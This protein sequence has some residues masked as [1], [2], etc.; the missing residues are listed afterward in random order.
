LKVQALM[1][2]S[3]TVKRPACGQIYAVP[4]DCA[5]CRVDDMSKNGHAS[6]FDPKNNDH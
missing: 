4:P 5:G 3:P 2:S 6:G 1:A